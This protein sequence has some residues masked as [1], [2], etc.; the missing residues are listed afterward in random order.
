MKW[1][2]LVLAVVE[3]ARDVRMRERRSR[4]GF[5]PEALD[6]ARVSGKLLLQDLYGD[7]AT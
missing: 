6:E 1:R 4:P 2:S 3:D 5:P 7:L